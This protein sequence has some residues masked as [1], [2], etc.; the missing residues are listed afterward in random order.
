MTEDEGLKQL[1]SKASLV[2]ETDSMLPAWAEN[3]FPR[4]IHVLKV[5]EC[6]SVC[7]CMGANRA[8]R[9]TGGRL[10]LLLPLECASS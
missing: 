4:Y 10:A 5:S 9:R 8:A 7:L 1:L 6:Q 2:D 3:A